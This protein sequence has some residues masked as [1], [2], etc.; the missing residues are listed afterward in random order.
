[1]TYNRL[2]VVDWLARQGCTDRN[3]LHII[4]SFDYLSSF[5]SKQEVFLTA[6]V[7]EYA[8]FG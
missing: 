6:E 5:K 3:R 8:C 2:N 7:V 1:L 4:P